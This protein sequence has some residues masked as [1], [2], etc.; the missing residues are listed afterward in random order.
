MTLIAIYVD[1]HKE[2]DVHLIGTD[3]EV[4]DKTFFHAYTFDLCFFRGEEMYCSYSSVLVIH[5]QVYA[6]AQTATK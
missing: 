6:C 4:L 5:M 3:L 1:I 2:T